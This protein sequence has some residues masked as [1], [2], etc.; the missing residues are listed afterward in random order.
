MDEAH[1]IK[2]ITSAA[3]E[4][5]RRLCHEHNACAICGAAM[6][7]AS[8]GVRCDCGSVDSVSTVQMIVPMTGTPILNRPHDMFALLSIIDPDTY[9]SLHRFLVN[10]AE[11]EYDGKWLFAPGGYE[12]LAKRLEGRILRRTLKDVGIFLD[13][14]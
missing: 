2:D 1:G 8:W 7:P 6:D 5:C 3:Y 14:P 10:Y 9:N 13:E 4:G 11:Q 12:R